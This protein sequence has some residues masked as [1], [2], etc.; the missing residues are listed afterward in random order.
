MDYLRE[1]LIGHQ[2]FWVNGGGV[3][4]HL[5]VDTETE[6]TD[7]NNLP[8]CVTIA[9]MEQGKPSGYYFE[10]GFNSEIESHLRNILRNAPNLVFHNAKFDLQ[11]LQMVGLID[12][13][14]PSRIEDT[15]ALSHLLDEHRPKKLKQLARDLLGLETDE[16]TAI[17]TAKEELKKE[18][19]KK[20]GETLYLRN[21]N[22][23]MLPREV[24]IPYAIKDVEFTILLYNLLKPQLEQYPDLVKLYHRERILTRTLLKIESKGLRID[25]PYTKNTLKKYNTKSLGIELKI[26]SLVGIEDFNPASPKQ[27]LEVFLGEGIVLPNTKNETL[28]EIEHPLA[29]LITGLRQTNKIIDYLDALLEE[30]KDGIVHPNFNQHKPITGRMSSSKRGED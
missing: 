4:E 19:K 29:K 11:K 26:K 30:E 21:I 24:V 20:T 17:K 9:W 18:H 8:F 2:A 27:V 1:A 6:G 10:L 14:D 16:E 23:G 13:V 22:Y 28:R 5:A 25:I 7:F 3:P 15:E 12:D